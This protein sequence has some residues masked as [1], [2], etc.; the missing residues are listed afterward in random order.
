M[1]Y[2]FVLGVVVEGKKETKSCRKRVDTSLHLHTRRVAAY[3]VPGVQGVLYNNIIIE[4][5][6]RERE[7]DRHTDRQIDRRRQR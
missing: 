4:I 5:I 7:K 6:N 2:R 1:F 3:E